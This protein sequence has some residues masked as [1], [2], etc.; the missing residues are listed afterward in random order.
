MAS[1]QTLFR[2]FYRIGFTPW[3]GHPL[4]QSVRDLVEGTA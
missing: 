1:K 4:A 3:D 2:L